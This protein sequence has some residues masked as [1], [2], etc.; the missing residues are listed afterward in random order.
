M[1]RTKRPRAL[2]ND[3]GEEDDDQEKGDEVP[4]S[5]DASLA[6]STVGNKRR[7]NRHN[8]LDSQASS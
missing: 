2:S 3:D 1:K 4:P 5:L 6:E 7:R 8:D